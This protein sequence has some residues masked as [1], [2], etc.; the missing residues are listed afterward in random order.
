MAPLKKYLCQ[1]IVDMEREALAEAVR[2]IRGIRA[3]SA[4]GC[5]KL[6]YA[7]IISGLAMQLIGNSRPASGAEHHISHLIEMEIL[8]G[9]I[10]ALHGEKVS[11]GL[12]LC[13]RYYH[14]IA[15]EIKNGSIDVRP[16]DESMMACAIKA[17]EKKGLQKGLLE[18]N[19]DE[20]LRKVDVDKLKSNLGDLAKIIDDLPSEEEIIDILEKGSC[21]KSLEDIGLNSSYESSLM[22]ISPFARNRLTINRLS[23]LFLKIQP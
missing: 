8:N 16:Y 22:E 13:L 2:E 20:P 4:E 18:E 21:K 14:R 3:G 5:E 11:I 9:H 10:D 23:K 15:A 1:R 7:L 12:V 19:A 17:F 6:M